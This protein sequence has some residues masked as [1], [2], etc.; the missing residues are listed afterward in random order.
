LQ[1]LYHPYPE[2]LDHARSADP[3][4]RTL[5]SIHIGGRTF[6]RDSLDLPQQNPG[7]A[8]HLVF[9]GPAFTKISILGRFSILNILH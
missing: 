1:N 6:F 5:R 7:Q 4:L 8:G 2:V 3:T 9:G